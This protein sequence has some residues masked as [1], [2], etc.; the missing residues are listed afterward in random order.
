[1]GELVVIAFLGG[2]ITGL[3]PCIVPVLPVVVAGGS[4]STNRARPFLIIGGLVLSFSLTVLFATTLLGFLHLPQDFLFWL[5]VAMLG[6]ISVGLMIPRVGELL[7]RPF[8]RLGS[9]RY[10][11]EGGG[12]LLGLSLGP[13]FVPCAGPV[14]TAITVA[15][16]HHRVGGSAL[17][18]TLFYALGLTLPLLVLAILA[19]RATTWS[20]MRRHL[21]SV[22]KVAGVVLGV[23]TLAIAFNWLGGL[24]RDVPGY[25][26]ALEDHIESTNS[27]CVQ[28]QHLSGEHQNQFAAANARLEGK[29]ATC[30]TTDAG[31]SQSG[32]L[33]AGTPTTTTTTGPA[34]PTTAAPQKPAV[35]MANKTNLPALGKAPNFTGITTWFNTPGNQPLSLSQLRGKVVLVD[36]WTYSCIN[37]QRALPHVEGWYNDY[38]NDGLVVV[39]VSAPEFSFEHVVSNVKSAAANLGVDYPVAV[40]NNLDTW[41]AYNNEYWPAEYLI[42]PTGIVRAYDFGEGGYSQMESNIRMLL[43]ANGV[44]HLPARTDVPDK[45]P[46][47]D[48]ITPESYVGYEQLD[49]EVGTPVRHDEAAVYSAPAN[50]PQNSLAFSGTWNVHSQEATAGAK[51]GLDLQFSADDVYLVIG[52]QGTVGVSEDGRHLKTVDVSGIPKLYTLF[53]ASALESGVL[54]LSVS[55]GVQA[56]DFTFG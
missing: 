22:R 20:S 43:S 4:S 52:G 50:I 35:F 6:A 7:E 51:A 12:F 10:A 18:V 44:Q 9:T 21:P 19:Q 39:G 3:S 1:M 29:K 40:D 45:T 34:T 23:T 11:T 28:L 53:S 14:L 48:Q 31:Q 24:Q 46:T 15:A 17:L 42:D 2:L 49:N 13:V 5:G 30:S 47:S 16:D 41:D 8:A 36:F 56:Y 32:H 55:P 27:A 38:K 33:A 37:C 26:N 54:Q 25:T